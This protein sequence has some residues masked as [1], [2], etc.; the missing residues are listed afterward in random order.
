VTLDAPADGSTELMMPQD[1]EEWRPD[2]GRDVELGVLD[3]VENMED[4]ICHASLQVKVWA[5]CAIWGITILML[6]SCAA[7]P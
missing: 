6:S 7:L 4:R 3:E 2:I 1:E 5:L